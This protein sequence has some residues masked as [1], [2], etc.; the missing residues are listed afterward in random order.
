LR[1]DTFDKFPLLSFYSISGTQLKLMV[2]VDYDGKSPEQQLGPLEGDF[3]TT[4]G[5]FK[6]SQYI[7]NL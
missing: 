3:P 5:T 6:Q 1:L 7:N 2:S 4:T